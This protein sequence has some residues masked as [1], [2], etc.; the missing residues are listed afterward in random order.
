LSRR[1]SGLLRVARNDDGA[2]SPKIITR[3]DRPT[4]RTGSFRLISFDL[5]DVADKKARRAGRLIEAWLR[6]VRLSGG[7]C[8]S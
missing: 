3:K 6:R 1:C 5:V 8:R 2:T 4:R 7:D